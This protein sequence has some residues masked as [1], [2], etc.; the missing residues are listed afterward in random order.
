MIF[1][2]RGFS[3]AFA[4]CCLCIAIKRLVFTSPIRVPSLALPC[5]RGVL[6]PVGSGCLDLAKYAFTSKSSYGH[7]LPHCKTI[8]STIAR[9]SAGSDSSVSR[10]EPRSRPFQNASAS[11]SAP[12]LCARFQN[13]I[14]HFQNRPVSGI[15]GRSSGL[16]GLKYLKCGA[17]IAAHY[18]TL[19]P[20]PRLPPDLYKCGGR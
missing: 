8:H 14:S 15:D 20:P 3:P 1:G 16:S 4:R 5:Q 11:L 6:D 12:Q 2:G 18:T 19:N 7:H 13:I 17:F 10:Y 9:S